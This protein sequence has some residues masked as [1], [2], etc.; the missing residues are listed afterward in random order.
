MTVWEEQMVE[1]QHHK[2]ILLSEIPEDHAMTVSAMISK[3]EARAINQLIPDVTISSA[4]SR[5]R[6]EVSPIYDPESLTSLLCE[7]AEDSHFM[8]SIGSTT[9]WTQPHLMPCDDS[10]T[11]D[12]LDG[13]ESSEDSI[14]ETDDDVAPL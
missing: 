3:G 13:D 14:K 4:M 8:M 7:R 10:N 6:N 5:H 9:A 1:P 12:S 2:K 11:D